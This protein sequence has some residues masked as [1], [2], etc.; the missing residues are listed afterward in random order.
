MS[1]KAVLQQL[2]RDKKEY[3]KGVGTPLL[4]LAALGMVILPL[5][6]F[7]LDILFSF[8]IALALVVL[9]VTVYTMKPVMWPVHVLCYLK[10]IMVVMPLVK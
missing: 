2:N 7:L 4:V 1:F 5:P 3:A 9:L 6:P 10:G 8:N